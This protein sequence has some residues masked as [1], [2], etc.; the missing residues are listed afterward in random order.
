MIDLI[1]GNSMP[2]ILDDYSPVLNVPEQIQLAGSETDW[3]EIYNDSIYK[4]TI[5]VNGIGNN[6]IVFSPGEVNAYQIGGSLFAIRNVSQ[7]ATITITP[8]LP[9]GTTTPSPVNEVRVSILSPK[10]VTS[11]TYPYFILRTTSNGATLGNNLFSVTT[12]FGSTTGARQKLNVFNPANSGVTMTFYAARVFDTNNNNPTA[13]LTIVSGA[14]LNLANPVTPISHYGGN[15]PPVSAAHCTWEETAIASIPG[16][17][18]EVMDLQ[19]Q[20]TQDFLTYPDVVSLQPGNNLLIDLAQSG[21]G[22]VVRLT[23]K[24]TETVVTPTPLGANIAVITSSTLVNDGNVTGTGIIESTPSGQATSAIHLTND[25]VALFN[26]LISGVYH[27]WLKTQTSGNPLQLGQSGDNLE[28]LGTLLADQ[29]L[30]TNTI[31]D[32][33]NGNTA[34]DMSAGD[35]TVA[36]PQLLKANVAATSHAG[37]VNGTAQLSVPVWGTALKIVILTFNAY[38]SAASFTFS[39]PGT[40]SYA[41][42]IAGNYGAETVTPQLNGVA[43]TVSIITALA[44]SGGTSGGQNVID[45]NSIGELAG[46]AN[47]LLISSNAAQVSRQLILIGI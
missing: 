32:N 18:V 7:K 19:A 23:M 17:I 27:Q 38:Q 12:G 15:N 30:N 33:T 10:E 43:S 25:G 40:I 13:N 41:L 16:S 8:T 45:K 5:N 6:P 9:T 14:D 42:F 26:I 29:G 34:L 20:V 21:T 3:L 22:F 47:Q 4:L 31:R 46:A 37:S 28:L 39:L 11:N 24:W 1:E 44:A 36:I 35:G 2:T